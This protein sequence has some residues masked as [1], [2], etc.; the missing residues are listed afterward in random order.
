MSEGLF[1]GRRPD[2]FGDGGEPTRVVDPQTMR[3]A[4]F[5]N[6]ILMLTLKVTN[7]SFHLQNRRATIAFFSGRVY[8]Q[9][10]HA[11]RHAS[12]NSGQGDD[13]AGLRQQLRRGFELKAEAACHGLGVLFRLV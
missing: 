7:C 9:V 6:C 1:V 5:W 3:A 12:V 10:M 8:L 4:G 13:P 11:G 2:C